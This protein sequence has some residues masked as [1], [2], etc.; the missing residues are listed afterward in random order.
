VGN[1]I[2]VESLCFVPTVSNAAGAKVCHYKN[3]NAAGVGALTTGSASLAGGDLI[4]GYEPTDDAKIKITASLTTSSSVWL[5][6]GFN[7]KGRSMTGTDAMITRASGSTLVAPSLFAVSA[8][9][10]LDSI[11]T[12]P[13]SGITD[14]AVSET[15]SGS[16]RTTSLSFV[17]D[18]TSACFSSGFGCSVVDD[19]VV[20]E[21]SQLVWAYGS[22]TAWAKHA[23]V[24]SSKILFG[25][26]IGG[27]AG[28][29]LKVRSGFVAHAV[30]MIL[31]W[32]LLLPSGVISA[33]FFKKRKVPGSAIA[34]QGGGSGF[35]QRPDCWFQMHRAMQV[36]GLILT[37]IGTIA[38]V[39]T[40]GDAYGS[41]GHLWSRERDSD[42]YPSLFND[43]HGHGVMGLVIM[44]MGVQQPVLAIFRPH[45]T[46]A[47]E[48][49]TWVRP[50][51]EWCHK[52]MGYLAILL[53]VC[54]I[55][56]GFGVLGNLYGCEGQDSPVNGQTCDEIKAGYVV[57]TLILG[58]LC[59]VFAY[60]SR[61]GLK[62]TTGGAALNGP[63]YNEVKPNTTSNTSQATKTRVT[64]FDN[65]AQQPATSSSSELTFSAGVRREV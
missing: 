16:S 4:L 63:T 34:E 24:G 37:L 59:L 23:K 30:M 2:Q 32:G 56:G 26:A 46:K 41:E 13:C 35:M 18:P 6:V 50:A 29:G 19:E 49:P 8:G 17:Y 60:L 54:Q 25:E 9:Y 7:G 53:A 43:P 20:C 64:T 33:R 15:S 62:H 31:G 22:S 11:I 10:R 27:V 52:G 42:T 5:A 47:G 39:A 36:S 38:I 21:E 58:A 3:G 57:Y 14:E 48:Q 40:V 55:Y 12:K 44:C 51:W 28:S 1:E 61:A 45:P 65:P